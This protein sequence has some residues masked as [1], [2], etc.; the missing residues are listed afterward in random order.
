MIGVDQFKKY[1]GLTDTQLDELIQEEDCSHLARFFEDVKEYVHL[2]GLSTD[3]KGDVLKESKTKIAITLLLQAWVRLNHDVATFRELLL[4]LIEQTKGEVARNVCEYLKQKHSTI[5]ESPQKFQAKL[6]TLTDKIDHRERK[7]QSISTATKSDFKKFI[8]IIVGLTVLIFS[9][10]VTNNQRPVPR[11]SIPLGPPPLIMTNFQQHKRENH[12]WHSIPVYTHNRGYKICLGVYANG[13]AQ[14]K[15]T[16][17]S[18]FI[19]FMEGEFDD[20]LKWP[21]CGVISFSV[22][23]QHTSL[24]LSFDAKYEGTDGRGER[25]ERGDQYSENKFGKGDF[26]SHE[27]LKLLFLHNDTLLFEIHQVE[28]HSN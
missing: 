12:L 28:L 8:A 13:Q 20:E 17:I 2:F 24:S 23:D 9:L 16:H 18:A 22:M 3:E 11:I 21:F 7:L 10:N 5:E 1:I 6:T 26:I 4:I 19:Q 25:V 27:K 15:G 14:H